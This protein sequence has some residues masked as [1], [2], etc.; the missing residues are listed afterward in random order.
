MLLFCIG[1]CSMV[2]NSEG[3]HH[4]VPWAEDDFG[5]GLRRVVAMCSHTT[6]VRST[7]GDDPLLLEKSNSCC[8]RYC[9]LSPWRRIPKHPEVPKEL[10]DSTYRDDCNAKPNCG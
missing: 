8:D 4:Q 9:Y 7:A 5:L 3:G 6:A 2:Q 1:S 10:P